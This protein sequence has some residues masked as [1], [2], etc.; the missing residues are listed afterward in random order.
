MEIYSIKFY[1]TAAEFI[2][3]LDRQISD[4]ET[5]VKSLEPQVEQLKG[6]A[7]RYRKI[8]ELLRRFR[9]SEAGAP[10]LEIT[11]LSIYI[12]PSPITKY[13]IYGQ[14]YPHMLDVL[15]VMKKVREVANSVIQ[16]GG[17]GDAAVAVQFRDGIPVKLVVL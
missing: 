6:A 2:A 15:S 14:S 13:E 11:G 7:E 4:L 9:Q 3:D 10:A 12:D 8:Q 17:L 16:E 1:K 5:A